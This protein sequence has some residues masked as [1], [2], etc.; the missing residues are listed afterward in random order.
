MYKSLVNAYKEKERKE[1]ARTAL[2]SS[3]IANCMSS[4][5]KKYE[6]KDFMPRDKTTQDSSEE[7]NVKASL[8]RYAAS[9]NS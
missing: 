1:D 7:L 4:G 5:G 2:L 8:M 3:I 6:V 9:K